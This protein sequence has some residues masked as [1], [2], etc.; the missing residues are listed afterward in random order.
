MAVSM[1]S[2]DDGVVDPPK[3]CIHRVGAPDVTVGVSVP[4]KFTHVRAKVESAEVVP[5][6]LSLKKKTR[7]VRPCVKDCMEP[8][9]NVSSQA[10]VA[11]AVPPLGFPPASET[12]KKA[13]PPTG[14]PPAVVPLA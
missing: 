11:D 6:V 4:S 1:T 10:V 3:F 13:D 9:A 14:R 5:E 2:V 12:W 8:L 7:E